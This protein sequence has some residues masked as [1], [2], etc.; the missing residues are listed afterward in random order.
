MRICFTF[1]GKI[2]EIELDFI[3]MQRSY[4]SFLESKYFSLPTYF[5]EIILFD[6]IK[7][8]ESVVLPL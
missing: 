6:E 4:S 3:V 5:Y 2:K 1:N 8:S 7:E